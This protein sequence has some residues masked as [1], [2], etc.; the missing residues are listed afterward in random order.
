MFSARFRYPAVLFLTSL[1]YVLVPSLA[2][3]S[4]S[5]GGYHWS[6]D[7]PAPVT[8]QLMDNLAGAWNTG[9]LNP[10]AT[11]WGAGYNNPND[12]PSIPSAVKPMVEG[13]TLSNVRKCSAITGTVQVCNT[14]Y[15]KNGWLG[16]AQIWI[17]GGHITKGSVKLNDTYFNTA[18]YSTTV[19]RNLVLCQEVGHTFGLDH[20]NENFSD[21]NLD[22]CMDYT[23]DPKSNQLPNK[24]DF[25]QLRDIYAHLADG[26]TSSTSSTGSGKMPPGM[27]RDLHEPSEWG[28]LIR[29]SQGGRTAVYERDF[30]GG[31]KVFTFVIWAR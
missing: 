16:V 5:W 22:T 18:K 7:K 21:P 11:A 19:W 27:F 3:A 17:S 14:T 26:S 31:H 13:G 15:G 2:S 23:N 9:Y 24:H 30:G 29:E 25:E 6:S 10:V 1:I 20:Q 4:H 12:P 8:V 28:K